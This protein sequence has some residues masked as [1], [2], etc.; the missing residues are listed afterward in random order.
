ME[1]AR[2]I[3]RGIERPEIKREKE[4]EREKEGERDRKRECEKKS[5]GYASA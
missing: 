5:K 4:R 1:G 2:D 3:Y